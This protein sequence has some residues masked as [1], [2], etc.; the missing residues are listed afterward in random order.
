MRKIIVSVPVQNQIADLKLFLTQEYKLSRR[1]ANDRAANDRI[2]RIRMF[3]LRLASPGD[4]ALCRFRPWSEAGYRCIS[5]EGWVFAY[6]V[7]PEGVIL[8]D[9]SHGKLLGDTSD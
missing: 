1:A 4:I 3:L 8:R 2:D 9:M 6:E 5:F 7:V